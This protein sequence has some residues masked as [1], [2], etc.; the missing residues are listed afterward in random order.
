MPP[1]MP[2]LHSGGGKMPFNFTLFEKELKLDNPTFERV[3]RSD[4]HEL[5]ILL[6]AGGFT[7]A[8]VAAEMKKVSKIKWAKYTRTRAYLTREIMMLQD[9]L[10]AIPVDF[11]TTMMKSEMADTILRH[12]FKWSSDTGDL[13]D[14]ALVFTREHVTWGQWPDGLTACIGL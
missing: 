8:Q 14:L 6:K 1:A 7:T 3:L 4:L 2:G 11:A 10:R 5:Y 13:A 9:L 12:E